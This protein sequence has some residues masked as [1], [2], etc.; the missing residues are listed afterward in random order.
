LFEKER[1]ITDCCEKKKRKVEIYTYER[2][3]AASDKWE[4]KK[5]KGAKK[6]LF[7]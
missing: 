3:F 1:E 7:F 4:K 5:K 2:I 6:A